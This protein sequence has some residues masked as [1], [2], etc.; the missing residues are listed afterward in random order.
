MKVLLTIGHQSFLLPN[1]QGVAT[2]A[3]TLGKAREAR[4]EYVDHYAA[5]DF[6]QHLKITGSAP[7]VIVAYL[8]PK[9]EIVDTTLLLGLPEH[10]T[11]QD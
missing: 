10:G 5:N 6:R 4:K 8:D 9:I 7:E 3:K 11:R 2:L 1:D